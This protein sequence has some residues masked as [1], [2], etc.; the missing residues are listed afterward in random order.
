[1]MTPLQRVLWLQNYYLQVTFIYK[2]IY[3]KHVRMLVEF[4]S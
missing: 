1:M 2:N 3:S 4:I